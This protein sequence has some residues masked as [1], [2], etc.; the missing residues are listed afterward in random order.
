[1]RARSDRRDFLKLAAAGALGAWTALPA[2]AALTGPRGARELRKSVKWGMVQGDLSVLEK[3]R[4]LADLGYDGVELDSPNE[5]DAQE[6]LAARDATG[7]VVPGVVDS[8]HWK[9]TLADP[10][11]EV[12]AKGRAGLETALRD[13]ALYGGTTV[14][15]VPAVVS[16]TVAYDEAWK[17]SQEEVRRVLP[18]AEELEVKIAFENVWGSF[19]LSPLEAARYVDEFE[20]DRVGWYFDIGNIVNYG[21]PE[22]WI[23]ILG[24]RILKL[25]VKDFSRTLRDLQG[26]SYGFG[27]EIG[28]GD[29]DWAACNRALREIGYEGWASAEVGGGDRARLADIKRRMDDVFSR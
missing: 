1:M 15:L 20:S 16:G 28:E 12:R 18:L 24:E 8:V 17:R 6:V 14:L 29:V 9:W 22:Q 5:L 21:W 4:L 27:V 3:F 2:G 10:D 11:P 19:L 7:L 23:R 25:D 26:L 13:C